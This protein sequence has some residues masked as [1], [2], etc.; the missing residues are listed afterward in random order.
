MRKAGR[1]APLHPD[2]ILSGTLRSLHMSPDRPGVRAMNCLFD[3]WDG[4]QDFFVLAFGR[5]MRADGVF[6]DS[7][8][9]ESRVH[10]DCVLDSLCGLDV[11]RS[12]FD[13]AAYLISRDGTFYSR[14]QKSQVIA[15]S[16]KL[17]ERMLAVGREFVTELRGVALEDLRAVFSHL[18]WQDEKE[19]SLAVQ[20]L[21]AGV[22]S[23]Y[24]ESILLA[25]MGH[26]YM[27]RWEVEVMLEM[28]RRQVPPECLTAFWYLPD[29]LMALVESG[30]PPEYILALAPVE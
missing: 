15:A 20:R 24:L 28:Q 9:N 13:A 21:Q 29:E 17:Y 22:S 16:P 27:H 7:R 11:Q 14:H 4:L 26:R 25:P 10:L 5:R 19:R 30:V 1:T 23:A 8:G 3:D 12:D 18:D 2:G 6:L